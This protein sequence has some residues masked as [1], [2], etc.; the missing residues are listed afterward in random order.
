L[1]SSE[2]VSDDASLS[3]RLKSFDGPVLVIRGAASALFSQRSAALMANKLPDCRLHTVPLA[4]HMVMLDNPDNFLLAIK[5]FLSE[6]SWKPCAH[7][8]VQTCIQ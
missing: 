4:G 7:E 3:E 8:D 1:V 5:R 6:I 2:S